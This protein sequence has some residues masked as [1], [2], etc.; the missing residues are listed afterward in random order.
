MTVAAVATC[1]TVGCRKAPR[2]LGWCDT[3]YRRARKTGQIP[4]RPCMVD[5][6]ERGAH[7][8]RLCKPHY[9]RAWKS[10]TLPDTLPDRPDWPR[11]TD[12]DWRERAAC[13][14]M[15]TAVFFPE[16]G[17]SA[18]QAFD[19]CAACP[20]DVRESC[21]ADALTLPRGEDAAGIRGGLT[22]EQRRSLRRQHATRRRET[23]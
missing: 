20:A 14:G 11:L 3:H 15:D 23:A 4:A 13:R 19:V 18:R 9:D 16:V 21:L 6:C 17:Q 12:P 22:V 8:R 2:A 7:A 5:G 1:K 10:R